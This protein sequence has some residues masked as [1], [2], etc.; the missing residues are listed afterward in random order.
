MEYDGMKLTLKDKRS[1]N[2]YDGRLQVEKSVI[3]PGPVYRVV[4]LGKY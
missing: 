2:A 4:F 1:I 3:E